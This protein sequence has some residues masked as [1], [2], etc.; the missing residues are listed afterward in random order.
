LRQQLIGVSGQVSNTARQEINR[1][2]SGLVE[3]L[4]ESA[5]DLA[6]LIRNVQAEIDQA[7]QAGDRS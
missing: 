3:A 6:V 1:S 7:G 4:H 5:R 2:V